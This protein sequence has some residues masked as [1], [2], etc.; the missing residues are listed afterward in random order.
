MSISGV[1]RSD[2]LALQPQSQTPA[3]IT[4]SREA[5]KQTHQAGRRFSK[6]VRLSSSRFTFVIVGNPYLSG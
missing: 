6:P 3:D 2:R 5:A 1:V 4:A